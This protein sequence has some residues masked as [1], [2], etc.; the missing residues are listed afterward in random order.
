[1]LILGI[2]LFEIEQADQWANTI[3]DNPVMI[4]YELKEISELITD[5][6]RRSD[7]HTAILDYMAKNWV[8]GTSCYTRTNYAVDGYGARVVSYS[9]I[10]A[11]A[12][13]DAVLNLI[14]TPNVSTTFGSRLAQFLT[15]FSV[16]LGRR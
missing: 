7:M 15:G 10:L 9:S 12:P 13:Y 4:D 6:I 2:E 3:T 5:P 14:R 1:M 11:G 16:R 8:V